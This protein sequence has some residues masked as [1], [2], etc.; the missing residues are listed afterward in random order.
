MNQAL[1]AHMN[2]KRKMEK[3][4]NFCARGAIFPGVLPRP[5][6]FSKMALLIPGGC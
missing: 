1:C 4:K 2:N 3:K 6:A 5:S